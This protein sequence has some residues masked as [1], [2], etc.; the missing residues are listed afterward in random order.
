MSRITIIERN[1]ATDGYLPYYGQAETY[2]ALCVDGQ[3]FMR[4]LDRH[5][6]WAVAW[7]VMTTMQHQET[8]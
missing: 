3:P 2:W 5:E 6:L 1:T 4:S 8:N 7:D